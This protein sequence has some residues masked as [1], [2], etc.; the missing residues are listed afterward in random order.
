[1]LNKTAHFSIGQITMNFLFKPSR[2]GD[3][4]AALQDCYSAIR[5]DADHLKAHFRMAKCLFELAW[6]REA[7][8][9]LQLFKSKFPDYA[10]SS[11]CQTLDRDIKAAIYSRTDQG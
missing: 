2:D 9:C 7:C 5:L 11:A 1:M 8:D 4:Y 10:S 6:T 3:H